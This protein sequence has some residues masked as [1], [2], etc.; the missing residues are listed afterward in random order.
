VD[1]CSP[2]SNGLERSRRR[3]RQLHREPVDRRVLRP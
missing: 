1:G 2:P 3:E